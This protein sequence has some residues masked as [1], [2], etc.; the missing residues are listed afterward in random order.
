[1][2]GLIPS[3]V[4]LFL[5][6]LLTF[7]SFPLRIDVSFHVQ[8][9]DPPFDNSALFLAVLA[10]TGGARCFVLPFLRVLLLRVL[11]FDTLNAELEEQQL[12]S[13]ILAGRS[14]R[15]PE[16][17]LFIVVVDGGAAAPRRGMARYAA[18]PFQNDREWQFEGH[19]RPFRLVPA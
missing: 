12:P 15:P 18:Q 11:L 16:N 19:P 13:I 4:V 3:L 7:R 10:L 5:L 8:S 17:F 2:A 14:S 9:T 6:F 1:V